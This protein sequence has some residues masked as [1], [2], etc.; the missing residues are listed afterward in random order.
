MSGADLLAIEVAYALPDRQ[1][2]L[3]L[4]VPAGTTVE[5][6]VQRS[7][8]LEQYPDIDLAAAAVGIFGKQV[9]ATT[10]VKSGDRVEVYR[11]LIADP[12]AARRKRAAKAKAQG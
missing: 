6:A 9:P 3:R 11:P 1:S 10:E 4:D 2:L 8:L 12:K 7:G 5:Q